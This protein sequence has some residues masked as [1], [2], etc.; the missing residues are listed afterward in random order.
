M[1]AMT[2][3]SV[4]VLTLTPD[5]REVVLSALA[6]EPDAD[7]LALVVE[8][9]G[10]NGRGYAYDLYFQPTAELP[11]GASVES[12]EGITVGVPAASVDRL[13]GARLEVEEGG[14][15]L[16]NPNAPSAAEINP[17]VPAELLEAGVEGPIAQ[18]V[19]AVLEAQVNPSIASHGGRADLVAMDESE[20]V[21][22]LALS[23]GCQ[24]C[25]MSRMTLSQ[26]IETS[27]REAIPEITGVVDVTDHASGDS[28]YYAR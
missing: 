19:I 28:P 8:I 15:V 22:Y 26:G 2:T 25:A 13:V 9:S 7:K 23:G 3:T 17:G 12:S 20:K 4:A 16:V 24:G 11:D 1:G 6:G 21:V 18:R 14:L 5:A 10:I 27:L